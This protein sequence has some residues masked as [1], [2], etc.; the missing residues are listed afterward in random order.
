MGHGLGI[1]EFIAKYLISNYSQFRL[2]LI[3]LYRYRDNFFHFVVKLLEKFD[4]LSGGYP[5]V[6]IS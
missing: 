1:D 6:V 5:I 3:R 2:H 4:D